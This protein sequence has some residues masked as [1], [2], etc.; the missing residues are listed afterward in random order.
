MAKIELFP[1]EERASGKVIRTYHTKGRLDPCS[2]PQSLLE[3]QSPQFLTNPSLEHHAQLITF[4]FTYI[5][6][7]DWGWGYNL[8]ERTTFWWPLMPH[9]LIIL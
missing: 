1:Y 3:M 9:S 5:G 4:F 8:A 2:T 6:T 7:G